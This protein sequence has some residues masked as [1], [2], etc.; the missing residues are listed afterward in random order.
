MAWEVHGKPLSRLGMSSDF[1][2]GRDIAA[3]DKLSATG[4]FTSFKTTRKV[5]AVTRRI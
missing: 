5:S 4:R 3:F 1:S 2:H